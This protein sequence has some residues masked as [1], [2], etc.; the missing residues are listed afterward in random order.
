MRVHISS[1]RPAAPPGPAAP[2]PATS[3]MNLASAAY[4]LAP[5]PLGQPPQRRLKFICCF[6]SNPS[7]IWRPTTLRPSSSGAPAR[8]ECRV[9][10]VAIS[11]P[12]GPTA[13]SPNAVTHP[14]DLPHRRSFPARL[15]QRMIRQFA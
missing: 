4:R 15:H 9:H 6:S 1:C 11:R 2:A 12:Y 3:I 5:P 14:C 8:P 10:L 13:P 7:R